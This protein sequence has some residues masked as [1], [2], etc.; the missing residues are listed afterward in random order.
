ML[1]TV[2]SFSIVTTTSSSMTGRVSLALRDPDRGYFCFE[3][4]P[5]NAIEKF[6]KLIVAWLISIVCSKPPSISFLRKFNRTGFPWPS[7]ALT[8]SF[9]GGALVYLL[10]WKSNVCSKPVFA[11]SNW[12]WGLDPSL[13][14]L[15]RASDRV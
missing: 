11:G 12:P 15:H 1:P 5:A 10:N 14:V 7:I 6:E 2:P 3:Q 4:N 13:P 8:V 9:F